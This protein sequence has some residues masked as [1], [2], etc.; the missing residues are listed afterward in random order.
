MESSLYLTRPS[1]IFAVTFIDSLSMGLAGSRETESAPLPQI[2]VPPCF[3]SFCA[4]A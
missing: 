4:K 3:G 1:K 2:M